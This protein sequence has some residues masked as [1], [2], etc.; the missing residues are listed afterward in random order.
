[1]LERLARDGF[2]VAPD[3][4]RHELTPVAV[5]DEEGRALGEW[6]RRE[7]ATRT[8]E[9]G[10]GYAV[11]TL[12]VCAALLESGNPD[13]HHVA[14]DPHQRSRFRNSGLDALLDAGVA[15]I[16]EL[17][18]DESQ[19]A[20]PSFLAQGRLFDFAFVDGDHRFDR[21]FLDLAFLSRLVRPGGVVF[22]DDHQLPAIARAVSFFRLNLAWALEDLS[23][24]DPDHQWAVLRTSREPDRRAFDDFVEF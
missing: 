14:V 6:V 21:V 22:V 16:V 8:L 9:I 20:L 13:V 12:Y 5:P 15:G 10:L 7:H 4:S 23:A 17:V 11:S 24:P 18:S 3:G 19:I 2:V 1:V